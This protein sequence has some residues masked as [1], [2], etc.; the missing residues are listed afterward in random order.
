MQTYSEF[1]QKLPKSIDL[2]SI[3]RD[4]R[5]LEDLVEASQR[6]GFGGN[7]YIGAQRLCLVRLFIKFE[8]GFQ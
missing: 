1:Q 4:D 7:I 6:F 5:T 3:V 2:E 8:E